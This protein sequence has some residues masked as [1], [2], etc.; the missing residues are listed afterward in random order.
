MSSPSQLSPWFPAGPSP[1]RQFEIGP[2]RNLVYLVIDH[3]SRQA[4]WVDPQTDLTPPQQFLDQTGIQLSG[5]LLTHTHPDHTAGLKD[6]VARHLKIPIYL[7]ELDAH[8]LDRSRFGSHLHYLEDG[9]HLQLGKLFIQAFHTPGHS[10]GALSFRIQDC[11]LTGD[12]L[13][14][15]DCGRT[16]LPTGSTEQMF[17][18]LQ[19]YKTM[20]PHL[21][22]FPGHHYR[23][24]YWSTLDEELRASPPLQCHTVAELEALP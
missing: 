15:R 24:E 6:L 11:L 8:R 1:I 18:T 13:F 16:D 23:E 2:L 21:Q 3:H 14:I 20:D 12:T 5:V 7:H 10:A 4:L 19:R 17:K 22:I 9:H